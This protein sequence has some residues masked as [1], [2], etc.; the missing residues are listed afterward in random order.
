M[1]E[2]YNIAQEIPDY[3]YWLGSLA[4]L[5][6]IAAE[7]KQTDLIGVFQE[8][9]NEFDAICPF[10]DRNSQG[11]AYFAMARLVLGQQALAQQD[12]KIAIQYLK[13]AIVDVVEYGS[14]AHTDVRVRLNYVEKDFVNL[15]DEIIKTLGKYLREFF[16]EKINSNASYDVVTLRL[17][18]WE[19]WQS[20]QGEEHR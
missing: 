8:M 11:I 6:T 7:R 15:S 19:K 13:T 3:V 20:Q 5:I 9:L 4:R 17:H 16:Q 2:S 10:P 12:V 18:K 1:R 14:Y